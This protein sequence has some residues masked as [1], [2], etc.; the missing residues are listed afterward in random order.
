M[1]L[2][3]VMMK[4]IDIKILDLCVGNEFFL[5]IYVIEG[6]VGLDLCVCLS[7]VVDLFSG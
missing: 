6:L 4:K 1:R 2:L 7:E 3:V 5:L